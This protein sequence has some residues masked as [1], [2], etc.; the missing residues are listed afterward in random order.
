MQIWV[1]SLIGQYARPADLIIV[2]SVIMTMNPEF[3][4]VVLDQSTQI[5][6]EGR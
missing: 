2:G 1:A 4:L 3:W 6:D 5:R